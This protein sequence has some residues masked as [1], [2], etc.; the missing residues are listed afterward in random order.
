MAG[1]GAIVPNLKEASQATTILVIP[2]IIPL[3]F[4]SAIIDKPN[5]LI[6]LIL[7][8]FPLTSPVTMMTRLACW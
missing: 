2:M 4:M 1:L 5:G 8:L 3:M 6:S 7:S